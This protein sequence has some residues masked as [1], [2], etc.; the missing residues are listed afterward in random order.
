M[1]ASAVPSLTARSCD[2]TET[3]RLLRSRKAT[4]SHPGC[5]CPKNAS[6][7]WKTWSPC[8]VFPACVW[9][10][11]HTTSLDRTK[12]SHRLSR[13]YRAGRRGGFGS[14]T[15]SQTKREL[16]RREKNQETN[17]PWMGIYEKHFCTMCSKFLYIHRQEEPAQLDVYREATR[18]ASVTTW[19]AHSCK[20][21]WRKRDLRT[22]E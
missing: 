4:A 20:C 8:H 19:L 2:P 11:P 22:R 13:P 16:G 9:G 7:V 12:S 18:R 21:G 6:A 3:L 5:A 17:R 1:N 10:V 15:V 14:F